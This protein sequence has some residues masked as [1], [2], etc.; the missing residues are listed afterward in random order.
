MTEVGLNYPGAPGFLYPLDVPAEKGKEVA[1]AF[2][3]AVS[4]TKYYRD[5]FDSDAV[6][7]PRDVVVEYIRRAC[8]CQ[9][10][11]PDAPDRPVLLDAFLHQPNHHVA[12]RRRATF[13]L[14]LDIASQT[15][16]Y[17]LTE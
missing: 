15:R 7:V 16:G 12:A 11:L 6:D 1:E 5:Y 14:Y 8:L 2:R 10:Q 13:C 3:Q 4:S 17:V 9:L